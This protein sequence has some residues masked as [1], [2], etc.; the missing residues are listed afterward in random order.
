MNHSK[1]NHLPDQYWTDIE[2]EQ[3]ESYVFD[4]NGRRSYLY[5]G[6]HGMADFFI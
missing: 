4:A 2:T 1:K 6:S 5:S 3:P